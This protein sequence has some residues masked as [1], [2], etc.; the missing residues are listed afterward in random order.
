MSKT[1]GEILAD[2][3][4]YNETLFESIR[5]KNTTYSFDEEGPLFVPKHI[6]QRQAHFGSATVMERGNDLDYLLWSENSTKG[7]KYLL[8][9]G[10]KYTGTEDE[11]CQGDS[12]VPFITFRS[13]DGIRNLVLMEESSDFSRMMKANDLCKELKLENKADRIAVFE[14]ITRRCDKRGV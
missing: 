11:Y 1:L 10:Y 5:K 14:A 3:L 4:D 6:F 8:S 2:S 13:Q 7:M 9:C 12:Q